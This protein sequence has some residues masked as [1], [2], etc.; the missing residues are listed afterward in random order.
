VG[1]KMRQMSSSSNQ[2]VEIMNFKALADHPLAAFFVGRCWGAFGRWCW[3]IGCPFTSPGKATFVVT[4][5]I[6]RKNMKRTV[7]VPGRVA[8]TAHGK[9]C[10]HGMQRGIHSARVAWR[11]SRNASCQWKML[12]ISL[13]SRAMPIRS[14][15]IVRI[16]NR[17]A[18]R[19][20]QPRPHARTEA[21]AGRSSA[22]G[23]AGGRQISRP[24]A[25]QTVT[26]VQLS[27]PG[28]CRKFTLADSW[29]FPVILRRSGFRRYDLFVCSGGG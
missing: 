9:D 22:A 6:N 25:L 26:Q 12:T 4:S 18:N 27:R 17:F 14:V 24:F 7:A 1:K 11:W 29:G 21:S 23:Q 20:T 16:C 19:A 2:C 5:R 28:N 3:Q 10:A 15:S 8:M 13:R